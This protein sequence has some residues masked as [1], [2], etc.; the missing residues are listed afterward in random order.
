[1]FYDDVYDVLSCVN[2]VKFTFVDFIKSYMLARNYCV[3]IT[4]PC[5]IAAIILSHLVIQYTLLCFTNIFFLHKI[6]L[7]FLCLIKKLCKEDLKEDTKN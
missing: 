5:E 7:K 2:S 6:L 4:D 1:M 3:T